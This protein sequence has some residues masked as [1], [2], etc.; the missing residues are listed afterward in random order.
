[1]LNYWW[2]LW[3]FGNDDISIEIQ[4]AVIKQ[5]VDMD[6]VQVSTRSTEVELI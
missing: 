3:I 2:Y 1:M 5:I 4:G 6:M